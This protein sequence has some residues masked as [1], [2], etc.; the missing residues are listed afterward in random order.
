MLKPR[1]HAQLNRLKFMAGMLDKN[2]GGVDWSDGDCYKWIETMAHVCSVKP[3]P[4]LDQL[5]DEWIAPPPR[6]CGR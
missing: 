4:E 3:D 5:M 1:C 2:P 6:N